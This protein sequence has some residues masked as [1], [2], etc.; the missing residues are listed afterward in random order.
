MKTKPRAKPKKTRAA[1]KMTTKTTDSDKQLRALCEVIDEHRT[2]IDQLVVP[3]IWD[4]G[5]AYDAIL[6]ARDEVTVVERYAK[7][8]VS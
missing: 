7:E 1:S 4:K 8:K 2:R 5:K 6:R 3:T